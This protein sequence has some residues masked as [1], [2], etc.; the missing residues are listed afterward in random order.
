MTDNLNEIT[1]LWL[2]PPRILQNN[3]DII[4]RVADKN[5]SL[6][7]YLSAAAPDRL[8]R[9]SLAAIFWP[10]K[11]NEASSY[12]L[13]HALWEIRRAFSGGVLRSD[14]KSCWI[15]LDNNVKVDLLEFK[16]GCRDIIQVINSRTIPEDC[17]KLNELVALYRGELLDGVIVREAPLFEEWLLAERERLQIL[18]LDGLWH[19]ARSQISSDQPG[20]AIQ[21]LHRLIE[22]DPLRERSYRALMGVHLRRGDK[23]SALK[24]YDRCAA[25]LAAELNVSPSPATQRLRRMAMQ[26]S[27]AISP[28][29]LERAGQLLKEG[30][31]QE[32]WDICA[33]VE[34]VTADPVIISQSALLRAEIALSEGRQSESLGLVRA[35]RQAL[36]KL[37]GN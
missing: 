15:E 7:A 29:E 27:A 4:T 2:G 36:G 13:R 24:V 6:I 35:A 26:D 23:A 12:R 30:Q 5:L 18:Y 33:V 8:P 11:S 37:F 34:S 9:T 21:T 16:K 10:E 32:A 22:A 3:R 28:V 20:E 25:T 14:G 1:F 17:Q 19:L 31:R